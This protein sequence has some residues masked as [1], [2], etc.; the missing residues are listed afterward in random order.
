MTTTTTA[1]TTDFTPAANALPMIS[2][3]RGVGV[4]S[5]LLRTPAPRSQMIWI[6]LPE[7]ERGAEG[8]DAAAVHQRDPVAVPV[9]LVHGVRGHQD[10]HAGGLAHGGDVVPDTRSGDRVECDR[11]LVQDQQ[12][13]GADQRLGEFAPPDHAPPEQVPASRSAA[14]V[15]PTA[16]R[17]WATRAA[18]SRRDTPKT[19]ANR[20]T[21]SRPVRPESADSCWGTSPSSRRTAVRSPAASWPKTRTMPGG[22]RQQGRDAADCGGLARA[23]GPEQAEDLALPDGQVEPVDRPGAAEGVRQP[24]AREGVR[25]T[26]AVVRHGS[27][28][29]SWRVTASARRAG[30]AARRASRPAGSRRATCR[31]TSAAR[32]SCQARSRASADSV[33]S[34]RAAR[35]SP[36][37]V[38][39]SRYPGGNHPNGGSRSSRT[40]SPDGQPHG[41]PIRIN[42]RNRFNHGHSGNPEGV[43]RTGGTS[44][45][46]AERPVPGGF[47]RPPSA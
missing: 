12:P 41:P 18:R 11:R 39:R 15:R 8:A 29:S 40:E 27:S 17:V 14:S 43:L 2:A 1:R 45:G 25:R 32:R 19:R 42:R 22:D 20:E 3:A 37:A 4:T 5:S 6:P 28:A 30:S 46:T 21:F 33:S 36:G 44:V 7:F 35:R 26:A 9:G 47:S 13:R 10:G 24:G 23:V 16:P 38:S 34:S 31:A